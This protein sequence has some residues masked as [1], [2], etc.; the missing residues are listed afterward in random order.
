[1]LCWFEATELATMSWVVQCAGRTARVFL[2]GS[3]AAA[4][5]SQAVVY[6]EAPDFCGPPHGGAHGSPG[7]PTP[8]R[9]DAWLLRGD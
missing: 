4:P 6:G 5:D 1:V 8:F 2:R 3:Y 9:V 7:H